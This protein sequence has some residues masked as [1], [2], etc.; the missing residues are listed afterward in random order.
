[1]RLIFPPDSSTLSVGGMTKVE[2]SPSVSTDIV[3]LNTPGMMT[4]HIPNLIITLYQQFHIHLG[5]V[6]MQTLSMNSPAG[7]TCWADALR[8]WFATPPSWL[9][10]DSMQYGSTTCYVVGKARSD[11]QP[12]GG[13]DSFTLDRWVPTTYVE[14][15]R[16]HYTQVKRH[17]WCE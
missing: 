3:N 17:Q 7:K 14:A 10:F 11:T 4:C 5:D 9:T 2:L 8:F 16:K 13:S 1:M 12:L 6:I 15:H